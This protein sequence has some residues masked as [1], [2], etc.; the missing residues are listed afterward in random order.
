MTFSRDMLSILLM[1][2]LSIDLSWWYNGF[3][4][5]RV[6]CWQIIGAIH[7]YTENN[8]QHM[9]VV[10]WSPKTTIIVVAGMTSIAHFLVGMRTT[11]HGWLHN[12]MWLS[13]NIEDRLSWMAMEIYD[14]IF[15]VVVF[16]I[17][18]L[19][20]TAMHQSCLIYGY[21]K[22]LYLKSLCHDTHV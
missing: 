18:V 5:D 20:L 7:V 22:L 15:I 3:Y 16:E 1:T 2:S 10:I 6:K 8:Y 17:Q 12:T 9:L 13:W 4:F 14:N 21:R 11:L 19:F